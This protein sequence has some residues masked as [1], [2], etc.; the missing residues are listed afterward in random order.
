M[1]KSIPVKSQATSH[2]WTPADARRVLDALASSGLT[3]T[4]FAQLEGID[5]DRL[6]KWR[7]RLKTAPLARRAEQPRF[8]E[9]RHPAS[10]LVEIVLRSGRVLRV[11]ES[12][13]PS[14]LRRL[15]EVLE[16]ERSC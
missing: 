11:T 5:P 4:Q 8:V 12:I 15:M 9:V 2:R 16:Q 1:L 6:R 14:C 3:A 13:E 7:R 10:A